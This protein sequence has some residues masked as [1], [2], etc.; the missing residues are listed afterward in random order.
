VSCV[1]LNIAFLVDQGR[2]VHHNAALP[3]SAA[4]LVGETNLVQ[5]KSR[6][7]D[8]IRTYFKDNP[9]AK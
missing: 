7:L 8:K 9:S 4:A 6:L 3:P 1:G 2:F 5:N